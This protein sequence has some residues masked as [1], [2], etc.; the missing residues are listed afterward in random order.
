[1]PVSVKSNFSLTFSAFFDTRILRTQFV[2]INNLDPSHH[3]VGCRSCLL[4]LSVVIS[5][6]QGFLNVLNGS[7]WCCL[8]R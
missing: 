4:S 3:Q 2:P 8:R 1:M 7:H 5:F 6:F